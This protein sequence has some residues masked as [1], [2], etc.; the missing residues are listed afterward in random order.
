M[1]APS[2]S[3]DDQPI[4]PSS[5]ARKQGRSVLSLGIGVVLL[6]MVGAGWLVWAERERSIQLWQTSAEAEAR[7]LAANTAQALQAADLVL[8]SISDEVNGAG[9]QSVEQMHD[10]LGTQAVHEMLKDRRS[11][12]AQVSVASVVDVNGDMVNFT[13]NYPPRS[14]T[15]QRIN[16]RERDYFQAHLADPTLELF[17]STA[18]QNKGTGSWTFYLARKIKSPSGEML[19]V[20]LAGIESEYFHKYFRAIGVP[21]KTLALFHSNGSLLARWPDENAPI[22]T[23]FSASKLF[24]ILNSGRKSAVIDKGTVGALETNSAALRILAPATVTSY[25]LVASVR[26]SEDLIFESWRRQ[27]ASTL[28]IASVLSAMILALTLWVRSL[29]QRNLRAIGE[30]EDAR[31]KADVAA[32]TKSEFIATMSHEIRTPMNGVVGLISLLRRT[33]LD[34]EQ[35]RLVETASDSADLLLATVNDVLD[36]SQLESGKEILH[37]RDFDLRALI[38]DTIRVIGSQPGAERIKVQTRVSADVPQFVRSDR[39]R[40]SRVLMNLLSNAVKYTT[41]GSVTLTV[42]R[43]ASDELGDTIAFDVTDTGPGIPEQLYETIFEPFEQASAGRF[44]PH[45]GTGLGLAICRRIANALGASLTVSSVVGRGSTFRFVLKLEHSTGPVITASADMPGRGGGMKILVAEDT[46][47]SQFVIRLILEQFGHEVTL[48]EN[49]AMAVQAFERQA[50]D[51]IFMDIQMPGMD[52]HA[53]TREIRAIEA[54]R[55]ATGNDQPAV[56]IVGLSAFAQPIDRQAALDSGM[57]SYLS[58]PVKTEHIEQVLADPVLN[59]PS[60]RADT[61]ASA[62]ATAL[63]HE[64]AAP[65]AEAPLRNGAKTAMREVT[66]DQPALT[67]LAEA[68]GSDGFLAAVNHFERDANSTL[69]R[70]AELSAANDRAGLRKAAHRLKGLFLQFGAPSAARV[71]AEAESSADEI[72]DGSIRSLVDIA[73]SAITRVI[74]ASRETVSRMQENS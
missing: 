27:T 48:V 60:Q 26:V 9:V 40:I 36:F 34:P 68:L 19:G 63:E 14:A 56:P 42:S 20:A 13:R 43:E 45:R 64:P 61:S 35:R 49:G 46:P 52:G 1:T 30:L 62:A 66:I 57:T 11:G 24:D 2:A 70:L 29:L 22:G 53:A 59:L 6:T 69:E 74:G 21:G 50:F 33:P 54:E 5:S 72:L 10:V 41:E 39:E 71:A 73:E 17:V 38:D 4:E 51:L 55:R 16:L 15:G 28:A 25:P 32:V 67:E 12:L 18:V 47:A 65:T 44:S 7:A 37:R 31:A 58:K 8:R 3:S 23:N